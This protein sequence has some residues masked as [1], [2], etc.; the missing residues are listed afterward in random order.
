MEK[1][2]IAQHDQCLLDWDLAVRRGEIGELFHYPSDDYQ[3]IFGYK[4]AK[5]F[6]SIKKEDAINGLNNY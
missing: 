2:F 3:G 4:E 6:E 1:G 5:H